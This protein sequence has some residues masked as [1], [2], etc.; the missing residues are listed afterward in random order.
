MASA[1]STMPTKPFTSIIPSA[2]AI[3]LLRAASQVRGPL[4]LAVD[5]LLGLLA[6]DT[7]ERAHRRGGRGIDLG[8]GAGQ[9]KASERAVRRDVHQRDLRRL[10]RLVRGEDDVP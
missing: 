6:G 1:A 9:V 2:S 5:E 4:P 8:L 7:G 10:L 3:V